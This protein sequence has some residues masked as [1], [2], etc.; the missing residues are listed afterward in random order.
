M[1]LIS[2]FFKTDF[3]IILNKN[4]RVISDIF[5]YEV[6]FE[7]CKATKS[8]EF[9]P[10]DYYLI[11]YCIKGE[12]ILYIYNK[13]EKIKKGDLFL[14]PPNTDNKY[15]PVKDNPWSY[16]WIGLNGIIVKNIL[17]NCG[18]DKKNIIINDMNDERI[19]HFFKEIYDN[20]ESNLHLNAL[21]NLFLLFN[22]L[23]LKNTNFLEEDL[24]HS[25]IYL[26]NILN[27]IHEN[28]QNDIKISKI[29]TNMNID[30]T[31]IY[32]LFKKY[33]N[34][35]PQQYILN[36]RIEKAKILL[37][38]SNLTILQISEKLGFNTST[39]F[40]KKFKKEVG[41]SPSEYRKNG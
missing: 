32:K 26:K 3:N 27:Y 28:Y 34:T 41:L 10:I 8:L 29:S 21:G 23:S 5:I 9:I 6:G 38:K 33:L 36:Y 1:I 18:F 17:E 15:K 35:S 31:Y 16:C 30:R 40:I 22:Y 39:Y 24:S 19:L 25:K 13:E 20:C 4:S 14:I 7:N 11:H 2:N 37:K 12:G